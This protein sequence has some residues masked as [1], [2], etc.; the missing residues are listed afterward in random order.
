MI[1][2]CNSFES[3]SECI[4]RINGGTHDQDCV[5]SIENPQCFNR[6]NCFS[7]D[8]S[9]YEDGEYTR[10]IL[11]GFCDQSILS[12]TGY[13]MPQMH[14][15]IASHY[16]ECSTK[17]FFGSELMAES[18]FNT[19]NMYTDYTEARDS[20]VGR[21]DRCIGG[22]ESVYKMQ[23][24][25]T[26]ETPI[27]IALVLA[28]ITVI[29]FSCVTCFCCYAVHKVNSQRMQLTRS[30]IVRNP[31]YVSDD[32]EGEEISCCESCSSLMGGCCTAIGQFF[33]KACCGFSSCISKCLKGIGKCISNCCAHLQCS[34]DNKHPTRAVRKK[35]ANKT[36]MPTRHQTSSRYDGKVAI[37]QLDDMIG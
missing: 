17:L 11:C 36:I 16:P 2:S 27:Y 25:H 6:K 32:E 29:L 8:I 7:F 9:C 26:Q 5:Y 18:V 14:K 24:Q 12:Q 28:T 20:I 15:E 23:G 21:A 33:S 22:D 34:C 30:N 37:L 1:L 19:Y 10:E 13:Q 31:R 35:I 3:F 4:S